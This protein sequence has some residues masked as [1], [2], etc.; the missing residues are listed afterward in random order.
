MPETRLPLVLVACNGPLKGHVFEMTRFPFAIGRAQGNDLVVAGDGCASGRHCRIEASDGRLLLE[1]IGSK[2]GTFLNGTRLSGRS[3]LQPGACVICVGQ[4]RLSLVAVP[5]AVPTGNRTLSGT[6]S[7]MIRGSVI[8]PGASTPNRR[9]TEALLVMDLC[10]STALAH[11]H[12]EA[13]V[14]RCVTLFTEALEGSLAGRGILFLKCT[15]DGF[16]AAFADTEP[17]LEAARFLLGWLGRHGGEA[18]VPGLAIRIGIHYGEVQTEDDG[19]RVGLAANLVFRLQGAKAEECVQAAPGA[20]ELPRLNRILL[21]DAALTRLPEKERS[22][23]RAL[24]RFRFKGF[25]APVAVS[26]SC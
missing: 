9:S 7:I 22:G 13:A 23:A 5:A 18:G 21:T 16:F 26:L 3:E 14:C 4:T 8:I 24:G 6:Q 2:N 19:D 1:D 12:G 10:D 20:P 17:A 15:G 11:R 25:E